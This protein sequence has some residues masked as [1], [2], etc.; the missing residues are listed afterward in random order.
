M[1][2]PSNGRDCASG[3]KKIGVIRDEPALVAKSLPDAIRLAEALPPDMTGVIIPCDGGYGI[4]VDSKTPYRW[5]ST[6]GFLTN[7]ALAEP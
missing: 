4:R 7:D 2:E 6:I 1:G 3:E 5:G